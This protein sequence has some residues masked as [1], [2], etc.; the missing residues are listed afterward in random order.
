[1]GHTRFLS[2]DLLA[3]R[4][5]GTSGDWL[6]QAYLVAQLESLGLEPAGADGSWLQPFTLIGIT[7]EPPD[8]LTLT[9]TAGENVSLE[10]IEDWIATAGD[11]DGTTAIEGAEIVFVGYG[12]DAPEEEW[13]DYEGT[14]VAG[15]VLL[16]LNNDPAG[17]RFA[18]DTRLYY[19]RWTYKYEIAAEKG[20]AGAFIIHTTPSAGYPWQVVT[21]SWSG[22]QFEIPRAR[23][24]AGGRRG[25]AHRGRRQ[26]A[27]RPRRPGARRAHRRRSEA[28]I[29][30]GAA[31]RDDQRRLHER[32]RYDRN[33]QRP[34]PP[35]GE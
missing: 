10:P 19:G 17:D 5:P 20:A 14:D 3:G 31:R 16:F 6:A 2:S 4:G 8:A 35:A 9:N 25:L 29:P 23:R 32:D 18:G 24:G 34:G 7:A 26:A 28:G 33:R 13:D 21:S 12:I 22:T 15:K 11:Q 1:M 27:H 30:P